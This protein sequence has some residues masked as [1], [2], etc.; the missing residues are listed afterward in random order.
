LLALTILVSLPQSPSLL[1]Q[2]RDSGTFA[3]T[4]QVVLDGGM[5]YRD[6][7]DNKPPGVYY[8]DALALLLFGENLWALWLIQIISVWLT[9]LAFYALLIAVYRGE[10]FA[11]VGTALFLF[12]GRHFVLTGAGNFTETYA[13]LP[14]VVCL[15]AGYKFLQKPA[16]RWGFVLGLMAS[17]AFLIKQ[18][19]VGVALTLPIAVVLARHPMLRRPRLWVGGAAMIAAGGLL[20]LVAVGAYLQAHG[21]LSDALYATFASP[22]LFHDWVSRGA[23]PVWVTLIG[24]LRAA[25]V[26]L[27]MGPLAPL[28]LGGWVLLVWH[29][30]HHGKLAWSEAER[31]PRVST[32][33]SQRVRES[34][35]EWRG[36]LAQSVR[37]VSVP[38]WGVGK[39]A[40]P[41]HTG[42]RIDAASA[43]P[44]SN[45]PP[46]AD[47][48][49][50]PRSPRDGQL[51]AALVT[52]G[53]WI[54]LGFA[55]DMVLAN[56]SNRGRDLGYGHYY[57]TPTASFALLVL[58]AADRIALSARISRRARRA[59]WS[60]AGLATVLW[61]PI[62]MTGLMIVS[63]G[64]LF[65]PALPHPMKA[66][67]ISHTSPADTVLAWGASSKIN[68]QTGRRSPSQF[69]YGYYL[70]VP[71]QFS[72]DNI[73]ELVRD[74]EANKPTLIIDAAA[75]D[76]RRVPPL[77]P[78]T[79]QAWEAEG[80][81]HD[82]ED[83]SPVYAFIAA[84]CA[85]TD[86]IDTFQV[87]RCTY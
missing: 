49:P 27:S 65:G 35:T 63:P 75:G 6:A 86:E 84:H 85:R 14:Q 74:L 1:Q 71:G 40:A 24:T 83:L 50:S 23:V 48:D 69:H 62:V 47:P 10:K 29:G 87:Y 66:Y 25:T 67:V 36:I 33:R 60:Y 78:A 38:S 46:S 44:V 7:W 42:S 58:A 28:A 43:R 21:V 79:R 59:I 19:T 39:V 64:S 72:R 31:K 15:L 2:G 17:L 37:W 57:L 52:F 82:V 22:S 5:P 77:D 53:L 81:R 68:F 41:P 9:G 54:A 18:N 4:A 13:L 3:Y 45:I 12:L 61:F 16:L 34:L 76:G 73:A 32:A 20:S 80:G 30:I 11:L 55:A 70:V 56:L 51:D 26:W 8:I